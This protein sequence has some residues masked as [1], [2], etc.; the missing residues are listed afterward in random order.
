MPQEGR[1]SC[2]MG[3]SENATHLYSMHSLNLL[4]LWHT[5]LLLSL[6]QPAASNICL[7]D[8]IYSI[9][10]RA[11]W[12]WII[13]CLA[14]LK[15]KALTLVGLCILRLGGLWC[16]SSHMFIAST[17]W[18]KCVNQFRE[19]FFFMTRQMLTYSSILSMSSRFLFSGS[20]K[21]QK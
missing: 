21:F 5:T 10:A 4:P 20:W 9:H 7:I 17:S 1:N 16:A 19:L 15:M 8:Q 13:D 14:L 6:T 2:F 12:N 3:P 18:L 11:T